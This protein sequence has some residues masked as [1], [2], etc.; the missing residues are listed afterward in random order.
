MQE[1]IYKNLSDSKVIGCIQFSIMLTT[2]FPLKSY[3]PLLKN[4]PLYCL[5]QKEKMLPCYN[6]NSVTNEKV[7]WQDS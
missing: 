3:N 5:W 2:G 7:Q 6:P 4:I 1:S